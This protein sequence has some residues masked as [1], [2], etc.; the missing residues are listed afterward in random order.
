MRRRANAGSWEKTI[1]KFFTFLDV[2]SIKAQRPFK[3]NQE[4][5]RTAA[6]DPLESPGEG[7]EESS[8]LVEER[9]R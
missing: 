8:E 3:L 2:D 6:K 7:E 9:R 5:T 1:G 4:D